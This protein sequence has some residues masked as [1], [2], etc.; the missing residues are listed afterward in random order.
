MIFGNWLAVKATPSLLRAFD[1]L[2]HH[3]KRGPVREHLRDRPTQDDPLEGM[4]LEQDR[5]CH[6]GYPCCDD[7]D[8]DQRGE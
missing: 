7:D 5:A 3:G 1:Q 2:E 4:P 6:Q 8:E